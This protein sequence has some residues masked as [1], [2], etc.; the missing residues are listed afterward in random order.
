[1][2]LRRSGVRIPPGPFMKKIVIIIHGS[3]GHP[4]ENWFPWLKAE[5]EKI[6]YNVIVP[7]FPTPKGQNLDIWLDVLDRYEKYL[8]SETML[9]GHSIGVSLILKKLEILKHPINAVFLVAGCIGKIGNNIFDNIN[10]S[11][12]EGGFE[13]DKI[14]RNAKHFFLY[15][16][17]NDPYVPLKMGEELAAKLGVKLTLVK[18]AGHFNEKAGY[19]KFPLLLEDIKNLK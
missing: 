18:G 12:F 14:R 11:F 5:L 19:R 17:D 13:W 3:F 6:G 2:S 1:M 8:D 4:K 10:S 7:K 16:S 15:H 9:V